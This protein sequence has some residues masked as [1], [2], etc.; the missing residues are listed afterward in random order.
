MA[1]FGG[2]TPEQFAAKL[3]SLAAMKAKIATVTK[4][5]KD[6]LD[7][8]R[9]NVATASRQSCADRVNAAMK[10][11]AAPFKPNEKSLSD[12]AKQLSDLFIVEPLNGKYKLN[13][14]IPNSGG[15]QMSVFSSMSAKDLYDAM[16]GL[17]S[18]EI[19]NW[20]D[21]A[22]KHPHN[23]TKKEASKVNAEMP[24]HQ[25]D[26]LLRGISYEELFEAVYANHGTE[27]LSD[28]KII[29]QVFKELLGTNLEDA[30]YELTKEMPKILEMAKK[31]AKGA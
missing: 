5:R 15:A 9:E 14:K 31:Y 8:I 12:K 13:I 21:K 6:T 27:A 11:T 30:K 7:G 22:E 4:E 26:S 25:L 16:N 17:T 18:E 10:K 23:K 2:M 29:Q 28:P 24:T 19:K 20:E 1:I 3:D